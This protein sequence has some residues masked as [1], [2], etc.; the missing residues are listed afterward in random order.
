MQTFLPYK[1]FQSSARVLDNKRLG[2]QRVETLQIMKALVTGQGWVNH[3]ATKMWS[4]YEFALMSYQKAICNEWTRRGYRDTCLEKTLELFNSLP[5]ER[6]RARVPHWLGKK[7]FHTA[8]RA[9][10]LRKD[11]DHYRRYGWT[12]E[13]LEGYWWPHGL[14][15]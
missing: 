14:S 5:I 8:H 13:P 3:P 2:K 7:K 15:R 12:E 11:E 9:N 10:L 1:S 4:G 6:R